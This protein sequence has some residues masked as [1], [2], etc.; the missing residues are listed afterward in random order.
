[1]N[2]DKVVVIIERECGKTLFTEIRDDAIITCIDENGD[3]IELTEEEEK[4]V[5]IKY[6]YGECD[7]RYSWGNIESN[8]E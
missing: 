7:A 1:M 3:G 4:Y 5:F 8:T 2:E 6:K